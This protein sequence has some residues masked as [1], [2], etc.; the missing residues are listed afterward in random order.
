MRKILFLALILFF[1]RNNSFCDT[2]DFIHVSSPDWRDQIIYFILTDRFN[3]GDIT[4]NDQKMGE[5]NPNNP[6]KY[7]GGDIQGVI[8]QIPYLKELGVTAVWL[9][10]VVSNQWWDPWSNNAGYHGYWAENFK[11]LDKHL[12][13]VELYKKLSSELHKNGMY[14]IQ[15]VVCNHVGNFFRYNGTY[16]EHDLAKNFELNLDAKP[17][18]KPRQYPFNLNDVRVKKE[19]LANIYNWTPSITDYRDIQQKQRYQMSDLDD[20][21]T[22]NI[23]VRKT[24]LD[25]FSYWIKE[26]GVDAFRVD[27]AAYVEHDFWRYFNPS[28]ERFAKT[29]G[30]NDFLIFAETWF[31]AD[32]NDDKG[33]LDSVKYLGTKQAPEFNSI[34]NFP[35]QNDVERVFGRGA[36]TSYLTYRIKSLYKHYNK[37]ERLVNFI[38]NHDMS[39]FLASY[40]QDSLIQALTFI[41]TIPG[42]P[43]I[44]YGTEQGFKETRAS[45]F[46]SG[47]GSG[48]IE[49]FNKNSEYFKIIKELIL[50]RK[51]NSFFRKGKVTVLK[52]SKNEAGA[53]VYKIEDETGTGFV[54]Y[55]TSSIPVLIDNLKTTAKND[56]FMVPFFSY[57][58]KANIVSVGDE[59]LVSLLLPPHSVGVFYKS[60]EVKS[61]FKVLPKVE[62]INILNKEKKEKV[63]S[64]FILS[65]NYLFKGSYKNLLLVIDGNFKDAVSIPVYNGV[66]SIEVPVHNLSNGSHSLV[67][68]AVNRNDQIVSESDVY[69]LDVER[70]FKLI[71]DYIDGIKDDSGPNKKYEYPKHETFKGQMDIEKVSLLRSGNNLMLKIKMANP[72][73]D[74]WN[75]KNGFDHVT[76]AIYLHVPGAGKGSK[77]MPYQNSKLPE[78]MEWNY[79]AYIAGWVNAFYNSKNSSK[80]NFG[81]PMNPGADV[82]V[83]KKENTVNV[84]IPARSIGL[85]K[86]LNGMKIYITTWDYD[87]LESKYRPLNDKADDFSFGGANP[88]SALIMDDTVIMTISK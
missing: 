55:N 68:V 18:Y 5:Y 84:I 27:T 80:N 88:G 34:I 22:N 1:L 15:D 53:F 82:L 24:L 12:G 45:M 87:G 37:P 43:S 9:T 48:D 38:D 10:P 58:L 81:L 23:I 85:P 65:G 74:S 47:F 33:D 20:L 21:N 66:W 69:K 73:T 86:E 7:S 41:M 14:L 75:P 46:K 61:G 39:R 70:P 6:Q 28:I 29:F 44:Y 76:F 16:D 8:D 63:T 78:N 4:N 71:A 19:R 67:V 59:G 32:P 31:N 64:D 17:F 42:I 13:N 36:P 30:K 50:L 77:I 62:R 54:V 57:N 56:E 35:M 72:I 11:E 83:N 51:E 49:H 52:D 26:V 25:S 3:D 40:K 79:M 60:K 2:G